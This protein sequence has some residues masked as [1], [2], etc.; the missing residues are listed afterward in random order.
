MTRRRGRGRP[1]RP[2]S[3]C[4]RCAC[5]ARHAGGTGQEIRAAALSQL[6][7]RVTAG[8]D[9][10]FSWSDGQMGPV[11]TMSQVFAPRPYRG[12][13]RWTYLDRPV[14]VS[15]PTVAR[16]EESQDSQTTMLNEVA[17]AL[18]L[19]VSIRPEDYRSGFTSVLSCLT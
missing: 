16:I 3:R 13:R 17:A 2:D 19:T 5:G 1:R 9:T 18:G 15:R 10:L 6:S 8:C 4:R 11:V 7:G 12:A 14:G